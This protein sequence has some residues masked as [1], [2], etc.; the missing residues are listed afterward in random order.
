LAKRRA[1]SLLKPFSAVSKEGLRYKDHYS[2]ILTGRGVDG[3][4]TGGSNGKTNSAN[5]GKILKPDEFTDQTKIS[6]TSEMSID[7]QREQLRKRLNYL[8]GNTL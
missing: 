3:K 7:E 2:A 1:V 8:A 6:E 4:N 5:N